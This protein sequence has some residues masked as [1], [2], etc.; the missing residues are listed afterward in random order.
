MGTKNHPL[1]NVRIECKNAMK[2]ALPKGQL[3]AVFTTHLILGNVQYAE[4]MDFCYVWLRKLITED[5][6]FKSISTRNEFE[7]TENDQ[8]GRG[9]TLCRWSIK[10]FSKNDGS[11]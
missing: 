10:S 7:L 9:I 5:P 11:S 8:M 4:L 3:D 6:A 1:N 2:V